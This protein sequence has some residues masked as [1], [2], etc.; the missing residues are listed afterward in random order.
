[1]ENYQASLD[2]A[3]HA[4]ADP[5]RRSVV[6]RLGSG[7]ATIKQ[8]AEPFPMGL[9]AFLKH[10]KVLERSG[11]IASHKV[12]RVR[13]CKLRRENLAAAEQW[14]D[15]QR[16]VWEGRYENLDTLLNTLKGDGAGD[17]P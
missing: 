4:L 6:A 16:T 7:S 11:L 17:E 8:L 15:E 9:P 14:F 12:G 5:T 13:T 3:F 1:M 10:I 2:D